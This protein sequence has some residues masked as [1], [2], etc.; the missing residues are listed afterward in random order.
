MNTRHASLQPQDPFSAR[1]GRYVIGAGVVLTVLL[2][3]ASFIR[4]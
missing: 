2:V 3:A 1:L 4:V